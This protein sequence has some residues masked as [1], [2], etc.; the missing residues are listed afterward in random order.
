MTRP[1]PFKDF[2]YISPEKGAHYTMWG[3][4]VSIRFSQDT[5]SGARGKFRP[6][7]LLGFPLGR[8]GRAE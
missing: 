7:T 4:S 8:Q 3:H 5:E 2:Y 1:M 6:G